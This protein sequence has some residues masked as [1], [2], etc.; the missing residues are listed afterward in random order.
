MKLT[1]N[2]ATLA[3]AATGLLL[4]S[5]CSSYR[6]ESWQYEPIFNANPHP[7]IEKADFG[8]TP[9][10]EPVEIYTLVNRNGLKARITTY[11]AIL[12]ELHVPDRNGHLA[13]IVLGF[14]NLDAYLKGHPFF[15]AT[16]GRYANRIGKAQFTLNGKVY[17]LAANNGPNCLHGGIKGIDKRVWKARD[18]SGAAGA[19]MEFSYLSPDGEEGFPGNLQIKVTYTLTAKDELRID[20]EATT[21]QDTVVNLTNHSYF[22]L[23]GEGNGSILNHLLRLNAD[24]YTPVDETSIP[25]G[26]IVPTANTVMDFSRPMTIGA[27]WNQLKG[28][29]GG[30][31]HNYVINQVKPG[32]LTLAADVVEPES[33][34]RMRILTTEPGVQLYTGNF[35]DGSLKGKSGKAYEK[36]FG[37]C[38]E[39]Q[40]FPDSPNKPQFPST[41]LKPGQVYRTTTV[42]AF[43]SQ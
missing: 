20:Y 11:G 10:G 43:S 26:D 6:S 1:G 41:V 19:A 12:T 28:T 38:L 2:L 17:K 14:D 31:D 33:G 42:H 34:R 3:V 9:E 13:D 32:E 30:Y 37:F 21:D 8:K 40:H 35:L 27:R 25:L 15:G 36:N 4:L 16:T 23:G 5:G 7:M 29:P 24:R 18:V 22:N 39:T